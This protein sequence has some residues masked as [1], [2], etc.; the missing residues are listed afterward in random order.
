MNRLLLLTAAAILTVSS[1]AQS[2]EVE[3]YWD[4]DP[5]LGAATK[6]TVPVS[7]D[8]S[9]QFSAPTTGLAPG[10]H[11]LFVRAYCQDGDNQYFAPTL[12]QDVDLFDANGTNLQYV[13]YFWDI[14]PG[15]G[16][17]TRIALETPGLEATLNNLNIPVGA[18][19]PGEHLLGVRVMGADRW[20]PTFTQKVTVQPKGDD[21]LITRMEYFWDTDP[22]F[23]NGTS[24]AITAGEE[25][26]LDNVTI[27]KDES[28][29][30]DLSNHVL[31]LRAY[32]N[33]RWGPTFFFDPASPDHYVDVSDL[34]VLQQL[35]NALG[36]DS[37]NGTKWTV[38][39]RTIRDDNWSGVTFNADNR[40]A[41]I[42]LT[43]R[44]LTGTLSGSNAI[45]QLPL[46][47]TLNLSRNALKGD[48]G[49]FLKNNQQLTSI[50]LEFNQLDE[51][52]GVC[53]P[54]NATVNLQQQHRTYGSGSSKEYVYQ[55]LD[56][57]T[58]PVITVGQPMANLALPSIW[59]YSHSQ[60]AGNQHPRLEV[61]NVGV[62]NGYLNWD[63]SSNT[64]SFE[65]YGK[66]LAID[67][68]AQTVL[69]VYT[70]DNNLKNSAW[71]ATF[72]FTLGDANM[73]GIIDVSDVQMTLD[74]IIGINYTGTLGLW[75]AN[76]YSTGETSR[77]INIQDIVCTVNLVLDGTNSGSARRR[78]AR[79]AA[80]EERNCYYA[81][82]R[83]VMLDAQ[84]ETG[85]FDMEIDGV[86][87]DQV[88]LLLN[89]SDWQMVTRRTATGGTR[90]IVFSPT[91]A[92][93]AAGATALLQLEADG[94]LSA[95]T[96]TSPEAS[97]LKAVIVATSPT[98]INERSQSTDLQVTAAGGQLTLASASACGATTVS[99]YGA[100]GSLLLK[101]QLTG[102][103]AGQVTTIALPATANLLLVKV[104]N[105]EIGTRNYKLQNVK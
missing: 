31:G 33:G 27:P 35:Y 29:T 17:A 16:Q 46:L 105:A 2:L 66:T 25:V 6:T 5:G 11:R 86:E 1:A 10:H 55:G 30:D 60:Q 21:R 74:Y 45:D 104:Q 93:L 8:G 50:N 87:P 65:G 44:G 88:K 54:I 91:G 23:G 69:W 13:E 78:L 40:V 26:T 101:Q 96:A 7:S 41:S 67:N 14:D 51:F 19:S 36:G 90:L 9:I 49:A 32:G 84:D 85:A 68:S 89:G 56:D 20:S 28:I 12:V 22:G 82:G 95:V 24:I 18:M 94:T 70:F 39:S 62:V 53:L 79:S 4:S 15:F 42:D 98:G 43:N 71:P 103:P 92:R 73:N 48:P 58:G 63:G 59:S 3:Y 100:Q 80:V 83:N 102:L 64:Y 75:A 52:S 99:V 61:R 81:E 97:P 57:I 38:D 72:S 34:A 37:W 76:T 77:I 47:T